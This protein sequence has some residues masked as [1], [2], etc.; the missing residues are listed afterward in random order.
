[1]IQKHKGIYKRIALV[2]GAVTLLLAG[3]FVGRLGRKTAGDNP[4]SYDVNSQIA[5]ANVK[6]I[7][8][9]NSDTGTYVNDEYMNYAS[10]LLDFLD[11]NY[12]ITNI[13]AARTGIDDGT[14]AAYI[15]IPSSFSENLVSLNTKPVKVSLEYAIN[16]SLVEERRVETVY[17]IVDFERNLNSEMS[18]MYLSSILDEFHDVQDGAQVIMDNDIKETDAILAIQ[19]VDLVEMVPVPELVR[20]DNSVEPLDVTDYNGKNT[21]LISEIDNSYTYFISLSEADLAALKDQGSQ[22]SQQWTETEN[23]V[24]SIQIC[25]DEEGNLIYEKGMEEIEEWLLEYNT[26]LLT[27]KE[28]EIEEKAGELAAFFN[29]QADELELLNDDYDAALALEKKEACLEILEVMEEVESRGESVSAN[30]IG[31]IL[32]NHFTYAGNGAATKVSERLRQEGQEIQE[33]IEQE[34]LFAIPRIDA[35]ALGEQIEDKVILPVS[36]RLEMIQEEMDAG[37][38]N[39][40]T[41]MESYHALLTEYDPLENIDKAA[42]QEYVGGIQENNILLHTTVVENYQE[43]MEYVRD[44]YES[45]EENISTLRENIF[46]SRELN[47][48]A[49]EEGLREVKEVKSNTSEVNQA[50][51]ADFAIKLPYTRIGNLENTQACDFIVD[52]VRLKNLGDMEMAVESAA[53]EKMVVKE[54]RTEERGTKSV[55]VW[56]VLLGML[57]VSLAGVLVCSVIKKNVD[58]EK[59]K[60]IF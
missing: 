30:D 29:E 27:E 42:I 56:Y 9:V 3:F 18:Y 43:N 11:E 7:A 39:N 47:N 17:R 35:E 34:M 54:I 26:V 1:M 32:D 55:I 33:R 23:M 60:L 5:K 37:Y 28:D 10:R 14:Y 58:E 36:E 41:A 50:L 12:V 31:A 53:R 4:A 52:P 59:E 44:V 21:K 13:E 38:G 2:I 16:G 20:V 15:L 25:T 24:Q 45:T 19:P 49:V 51:L 40:R 57:I 46:D 6:T 22:L 8:V 48:Q